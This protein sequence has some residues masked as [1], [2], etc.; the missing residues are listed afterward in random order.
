[1]YI[2]IFITAVF[3]PWGRNP[4]LIVHGSVAAALLLAG[5]ALRLW[6]IRYMGRSNRTQRAKARALMTQGPFALTRNPL[7]VSNLTGVAGFVLLSGL[8]WFVVPAVALAWVWYDVIVRWEEKLLEERFGLAYAGY[9]ERVPR[10]VSF[11]RGGPAG[12]AEAPPQSWLRALWLE[13]NAWI[14]GIAL[15]AAILLVRRVMQR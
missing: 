11:R 10:W 6:A 2:P 15:A 7:Y 5:I 9:R 12:E 4:E 14:G 3:C 8:D 1:M 13:R